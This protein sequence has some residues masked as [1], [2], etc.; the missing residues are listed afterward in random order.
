MHEAGVLVLLRRDQNIKIN[1]ICVSA[2]EELMFE[3][4]TYIKFLKADLWE[5]GIKTLIIITHIDRLSFSL[6]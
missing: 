5:K 2:I 4:M 1:L 3:E 6:E